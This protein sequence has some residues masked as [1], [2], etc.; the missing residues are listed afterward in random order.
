[1]QAGALHLPEILAQES[2][3]VRIPFTLPED[4]SAWDYWLNMD[5][6]LAFDTSW[7]KQGHEV[8]KAQFLVMSAGSGRAGG[9][10]CQHRRR[11]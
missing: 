4:R 7:G 6:T 1:M 8:A 9:W 10:I 5:F 3:L 2:A 11:D